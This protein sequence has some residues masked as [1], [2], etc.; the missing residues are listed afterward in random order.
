MGWTNALDR[1]L[2]TADLKEVGYGLFYAGPENC[3]NGIWAS[4]CPSVGPHGTGHIRLYGLSWKLV[5][6]DFSKMSWENCSFV[7]M[8]RVAGA[9]HEDLRTSV[10]SRRVLLRVRN[11]SYKFAEKI[12]TK[13]WYS[14]DVFSENRVVYEI[15]LRTRWSQRRYMLDN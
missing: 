15:W 2:A 6:E 8:W 13:I 10:M 4:T 9:F 14:V 1:P 3:E 7:K 5:F 11:V 12:K